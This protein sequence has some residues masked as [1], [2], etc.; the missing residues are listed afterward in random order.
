MPRSS[1]HKSH[2][3]SKHKELSE[4]EEDVR[5][6]YMNGK[7][8][9]SVVEKRKV[10]GD[11]MIESG[12]LKRKR[13]KTESGSAT[14]RWNSGGVDVDKNSRS[15]V[16]SDLRS[17]STRK[18]ESGN[19]K[20]EEMVEKEESKTGSKVESKRKSEKDQG[21]KEAQQTKDVKESKDRDKGSEKKVDSIRDLEVLTKQG[22][23][24]IDLNGEK[25][26]KRGKENA[27]LV[28]Q[29]DFRNPELEKELE[30]RIRRRSDSSREKHQDDHVKDSE[31][32]RISSKSD[33]AKNGRHKDEKHKDGSYVDKQSEDGEKESRY[34]E[35]K[36]HEDHERDKRNKDGKHRDSKYREDVD[37][38]SRHKE[39]KYRDSGHRDSHYE[40]NNHRE[41]GDK[42][43]KRREAKYLEDDNVDNRYRDDKH[44]E[45]SNGESKDKDDKYHDDRRRD[46]KYH[47][48]GRHR[49]ERHRE[50]VDKDIK[51]RDGKPRDDN[52]RVKRLRDIKYRDEGTNDK[53][54]VKR[55]RND[56]NA[57]ECHKKSTNQ[58]VYDHS[59]RD[60]DDKERRRGTDKD[61]SDSRSN[62]TK[63]QTS[64]ADKKYGGA[65]IDAV[66]D[67]GKSSSRN[68][69]GESS[70][71]RS[72]RRYPPNSGASA[73]IQSR[74]SIQEDVYEERTW[75]RSSSKKEFGGAVENAP[76]SRSNERS[77]NK[78]DLHYQELSVERRQKLDSPLQLADKSPSSAS[79]ERR[80]FNRSD[81]RRSLDIDDSK[82]YPS[83]EGRGS[84]DP[85]METFPGNDD[86]LS[87]SSSFTR[88]NN[89]TSLLPPPLFRNGSDNHTVNGS[90]E[91]DSRGKYYNRHRRV[92]GDSN[93]MARPPQGNNNAWK[94]IQNWPSPVANGFMPFQHGPPTPVGFHPMMQQFPGPPIFGIRPPME[95]N[96][97]GYGRPLGWRNPMDDL[98]NAVFRDESHMYGRLGWDQSRAIAGGVGV[99]AWD[100]TRQDS[101]KATVENNNIQGPSDEVSA[102]Q[103]ENDQNLQNVKAVDVVDVTQPIVVENED[104]LATKISSKEIQKQTEI[105]K[106][107]DVS[108]S[109]TIS[110]LSKMD[111]SVDLAVPDLYYGYMKFMEE[112]LDEKP[113]SDK[114]VSVILYLEG[115]KQNRSKSY[116]QTSKSLPIP[117]TN[118]AILKK[119]MSV[120]ENHSEGGM[121]KVL[122]PNNNNKEKMNVN[123]ND[124]DEIVSEDD[125]PKLAEAEEVEETIQL[126]DN[127]EKVKVESPSS[128]P[129]NQH[130]DMLLDAADE[131]EG[132]ADMKIDEGSSLNNDDDVMNNLEGGKTPTSP[133]LEGESLILSDV[134]VVVVAVAVPPSDSDGVGSESVNLSHGRIHQSSE[135]TH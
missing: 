32:R 106:K 36:Y 43:R 80:H 123:V 39:D 18:H 24:S 68:A 63:D 102:M 45:N 22:S 14:D 31:S 132:I 128:S 94:G 88:S 41:D 113:N 40:D 38:E 89:H 53:S 20:K 79:T 115:S 70:P 9:F 74:T 26:V 48:D 49:E 83:K 121:Y 87:V 98:N 82:D 126:Q 111:V 60:K 105:L 28:I 6:K 2:K 117:A 133:G 77:I 37:R 59:R 103:T 56:S 17:K 72:R 35:D 47:E 5:M 23:L 21:R 114:D 7:D 34:K 93:N 92:G 11:S 78:D 85:T 69:D 110:Y 50:D 100:A 65:R 120:Y 99:H 90:M 19:E 127:I 125:K 57:S 95:L 42:G 62:N 61:Y 124:A 30:K 16:S 107:K 118:E 12:V 58:D 46:D 44:H 66:S 13:E 119:A 130:K 84:R 101:W 8:E 91:E 97:S 135:S 104:T 131:K 25:Q 76:I 64:E 54:D 75:N 134:D 51:H 73:K 108:L 27:D 71:S 1:R 129:S 29:D 33:H 4:S 3:Q 67:Q 116:E 15:K 122:Q 10:S 96:H 52:D 55:L 86:T 112:D 109:R 81:A